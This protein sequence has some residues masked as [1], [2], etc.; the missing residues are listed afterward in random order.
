M[1]NR[2]IREAG[3]RVPYLTIEALDAWTPL[4]ITVKR[5]EGYAKRYTDGINGYFETA[6]KRGVVVQVY[7]YMNFK[8]E[9]VKIAK[10]FVFVVFE[11]G[12]AVPQCDATHRSRFYQL[13]RFVQ[14]YWATDHYRL[15]SE[16][17]KQPV[18][19]HSN[20]PQYLPSLASEFF[21][22]P[23]SAG[24]KPDRLTRMAAITAIGI[25][26]RTSPSK[27]RQGALLWVPMAHWGCAVVVICWSGRLKRYLIFHS[28][29]PSP[30]RPTFEITELLWY[31]FRYRHCHFQVL[32]GPKIV[33]HGAP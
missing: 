10:H 26:M 32:E 8:T 33:K 29:R 22:V 4:A 19:E 2:A 30:R 20:P 28:F 7:D 16:V 14:R 12:E 9:D 24:R 31:Q 23:D 5:L 18:R 17:L 6:E 25:V 3:F 11:V 21:N 15:S 27:W 1:A 13:K